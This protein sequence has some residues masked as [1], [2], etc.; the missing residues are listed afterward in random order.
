MDFGAWFGIGFFVVILVGY[1]YLMYRGYERWSSDIS[2]ELR[3][4]RD[5]EVNWWLL[6]DDDRDWFR[7]QGFDGPNMDEEWSTECI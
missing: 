3:E 4:R 5:A 7:S 6:S 2:R 1:C